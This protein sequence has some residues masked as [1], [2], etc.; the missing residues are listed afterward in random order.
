MINFPIIVEFVIAIK[1][2]LD[3]CNHVNK[4]QSKYSNV[5]FISESW[6]RESEIMSYILKV[7]RFG[8]DMRFCVIFVYAV[9]Q[10]WYVDL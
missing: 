10:G 1:M 9:E 5:C 2:R 6:Y 7:C 3:S 8:Y 4:T